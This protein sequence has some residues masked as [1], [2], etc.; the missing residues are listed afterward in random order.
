MRLH[1][2]KWAAWLG[3]F[4]LGLNALVPIH[5]AFDLA[6]ALAPLHHQP[7]EGAG[8]GPDPLLLALIWHHH[9]AGE[10]N[11]GDHDGKPSDHACPVCV[12][13][14]NLIGLGLPAAPPLPV[15]V[16]AT[17]VIAVVPLAVLRGSVAAAAYH[18]R[19]PPLA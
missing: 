17:R 3:V 15:L 19:A 16:A 18:A 8:G 1:R 14:G 10:D 6:D 7:I 11:D 2:S 4:A 13:A 9:H 5:F 12:A